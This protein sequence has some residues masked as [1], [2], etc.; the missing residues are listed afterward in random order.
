MWSK[1][2]KDC[3]L[4]FRRVVHISKQTDLVVVSNTIDSLVYAPILREQ[5][6]AFYWPAVGDIFIF[7]QD[8]SSCHT[9]SLTKTWLENGKSNL[10]NVN[11]ITRLKYN[12]ECLGSFSRKISLHWKKI[13]NKMI[14]FDPNWMKIWKNVLKGMDAQRITNFVNYFVKILRRPNKY[15]A[16]DK[17]IFLFYLL[18]LTIKR[19]PVTLK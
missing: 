7:Q 11:K 19:L 6:L 9:S 3:T 12:W 17:L 1:S 8:V 15:G 14:N 4:V 5:L 13:H 2:S 10:Y 16:A 18:Y